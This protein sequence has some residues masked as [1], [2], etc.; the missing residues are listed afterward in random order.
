MKICFIQDNLI[1]PMEISLK[2]YYKLL[3]MALFALGHQIVWIRSSTQ[4]ED[5]YENGVHIIGINVKPSPDKV[6]D[7]IIFRKKIMIK[8]EELVALGEIDIIEIATHD[9]LG[10][11]YLKNRQVPVIG[12]QHFPIDY[13]LKKTATTNIKRQLTYWYEESCKRYDKIIAA[14]NTFS[15]HNSEIIMDPIDNN[16]FYP[17]SIRH[18]S[19]MILHCGPLNKDGGVYILAKAIN[20]VL[21]QL[22]DREISFCFVGKDSFDETEHIKVSTK[23]KNYI[24]SQYHKQ[25][26]FLGEI[27][28]LNLNTIY[29]EAQIG[30]ASSLTPINLD[31]LLEPQLCCLPMIVA[32]NSRYLEALDNNDYVLWYQAQD[33]RSLAR[34]IIRLYQN[35]T[36]T[37]TLTSNARKYVLQKYQPKYIACQMLKVYNET[38]KKFK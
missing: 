33:Y 30:I 19:K 11:F 37:K 27:P 29:N 35:I 9:S 2:K 23:I 10:Y 20:L 26:V 21:K 3:S 25:I 36:I 15:V 12:K 1:E 17:T 8:I 22:N 7:N 16:N 31:Y 34:H 5:Y 32:N 28:P 6:K 38:I 4:T 24:D 14:T 18:H 13:L